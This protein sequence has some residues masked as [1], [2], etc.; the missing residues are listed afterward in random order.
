MDGTSKT[1]F[2]RVD[3]RSDK[4]IFGIKDDDRFS[5]VYVIGKTGRENQ[6]SLKRW[7]SRILSAAR[8]SPSLILMA[9]WSTES[10]DVFPSP[11]GAMS[12]PPEFA[13]SAFPLPLFVIARAS[14]PLSTSPTEG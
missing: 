8:A 10:I 7:R 11:V 6:R 13:L 1:L 12:F 4:R 2:A 3:L 14:I 9:I 5:H